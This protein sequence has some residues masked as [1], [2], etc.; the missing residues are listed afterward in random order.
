M[1][2]GV[3]FCP[4][5]EAD[6]VLSGRYIHGAKKWNGSEENLM[7]RN[8]ADRYHFLPAETPLLADA[9]ILDFKL[10]SAVP[11]SYL[12]RWIRNHRESRVA[13]LL[14]PYRDRLTQ[15]FTNYFGR[16]AEP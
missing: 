14:P 10:V 2:R 5:W 9:L 6:E 16:I 15:R 12:E 13:V 1:L 3:L 4:A 8:G 11:P 7:K